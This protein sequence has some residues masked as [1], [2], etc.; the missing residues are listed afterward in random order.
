M[1]GT[2]A[3]GCSGPRPLPSPHPG[4]QTTLSSPL[5]LPTVG[6]GSH[7]PPQGGHPPP[8]A[9]GTGL[10]IPVQSAGAPASL[11]LAGGELANL[12]AGRAGLAGGVGRGARPPLGLG[13]GAQLSRLRPVH[14]DGL[15]QPLAAALP[16]LPCLLLLRHLSCKGRETVRQ[17]QG[18]GASPPPRSPPSP[19]SEATLLP[20]GSGTPCRTFEDH[21]RGSPKGDARGREPTTAPPSPL[22]PRAG[23][24]PFLQHP[25]APREE[26]T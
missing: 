26:K 3:E 15:G 8:S 4:L 6:A 12:A 23:A 19:R 9:A 1:P 2:F 13:F 16:V 17:E 25:A 11:L 5:L 21:R 14:A 7:V 20:G 10:P 24:A 22:P 18:P